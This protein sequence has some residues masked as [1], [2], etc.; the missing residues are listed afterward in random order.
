MIKTQ[1]IWTFDS[2]ADMGI[3]TVPVGGVFSVP[4]TGG[5]ILYR[6]STIFASDIGMTI[7]DYITQGNGYSLYVDNY[8]VSAGKGIEV[9]YDVGDTAKL[10]PV[11]R[12][13]PPRVY[14]PTNPVLVVGGYG[15]ANYSILVESTS[16]TVHILN[17]ETVMVN[18]DTCTITLVGDIGDTGDIIVTY[19]IPGETA[20]VVWDSNIYW[21][22]PNNTYSP[23]ILPATI[24]APDG[25][26]KGVM[27]IKYM[28]MPDGVVH[29]M[30]VSRTLYSTPL[31]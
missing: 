1:P 2:L 30:L 22:D 18:I 7:G 24:P 13:S 6:K 23:A 25:T 15:Q 8:G 20:G 26:G 14:S 31:V 19:A 17:V 29:M 3:D 9:N 10:S 28:I 4:T 21:I 5:N 16:A 11:V 27:R 12:T